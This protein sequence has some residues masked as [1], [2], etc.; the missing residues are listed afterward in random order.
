MDDLD[1]FKAMMNLA[2]GIETCLQYPAGSVAQHRCLEELGQDAK[3]YLARETVRQQ[4]RFIPSDD[5]KTHTGR[6]QDSTG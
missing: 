5:D 3:Y 6:T 2:K 1:Y 4:A